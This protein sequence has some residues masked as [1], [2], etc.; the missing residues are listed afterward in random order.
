MPEKRL[1]SENNSLV[2]IVLLQVNPNRIESN[3]RERK[4]IISKQH[5]DL[6]LL[7]QMQRR[8]IHFGGREST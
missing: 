3:E 5:Q 1:E 2:V 6:H 7:S 4:K 8:I